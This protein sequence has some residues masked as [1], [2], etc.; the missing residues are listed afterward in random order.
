[1]AAASVAQNWITEQSQSSSRIS[2]SRTSFP[3]A[4]SYYNKT[5]YNS[6]HYS[7]PRNGN[8]TILNRHKSI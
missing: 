3:H 6:D 4:H 1:M 5:D 7:F 8:I 2:S